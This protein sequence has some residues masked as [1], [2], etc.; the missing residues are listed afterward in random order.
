MHCALTLCFAKVLGNDGKAEKPLFLKILYANKCLNSSK[1]FY[2]RS[3]LK[4]PM[5]TLHQAQFLVT[6]NHLADLP[7]DPLPEV[8][9]AGR[10]NAGKSTAINVLC[11]QNRLAFASKTPGRT[12]HI[13]FF[14]ILTK[15]KTNLANLVDLPGYGYAQVDE[16]T[17]AHWQGLLSQYLQTRPQLSGL[18]LIM[19]ARRGMTALDQQMVEWFSGTGKPIHV[20]LTKAD[21]LNQSEGRMALEKLKK[22]L[23]A[24]C[25]PEQWTAQLFS[26]T[27]RLGLAQADQVIS[28]WLG[29]ESSTQHIANEKG[30]YKKQG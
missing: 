18:I 21:K 8:A 15:D 14:T 20:L 7:A 10:S 4:T 5:S 3:N 2:N 13:N 24:V 29:I 27:K 16:K 11:Q 23:G 17:R 25:S 19:D 30:S 12:Q 6:V 22:E 1:E 26:S 28:A 9:F